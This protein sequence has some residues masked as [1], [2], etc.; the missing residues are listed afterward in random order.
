ME[1]F[2]EE[3][4]PASD[5]HKFEER[6]NEEIRTTGKVS[7]PLRFINRNII[8]L[9]PLKVTAGTQFEYG[10]CLVRSKYPAD[11]RKGIALLE[12]LVQVS[13]DTTF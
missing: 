11:V 5:L 3:T 6:Y 9:S 2:L 10:W 4:V 12:D 13:S 7:L 8:S 1:F